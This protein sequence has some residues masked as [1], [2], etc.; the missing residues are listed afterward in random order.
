MKF[1]RFLSRALLA[2]AVLVALTTPSAAQPAAPRTP[3]PAPAQPEVTIA[4]IYVADEAQVTALANAGLDLLETRGPDYLVA[5]LTRAEREAVTAR[6][7]RVVVDQQQTA[8][9]QSYPQP[10]GPPG[11]ACYRSVPA[12]EAFLTQVAADHPNLVELID[13][14]DSWEKVTPGGEPGHDLWVV[15]ITNQAVPAPAGQSKPRFFLMANIHA[16]ELTTPEVAMFFIQTLV[17]GH[18]VDPDITWIVDHHE[19]W[20][21][22]TANPDG[23]NMAERGLLWRKNTDNDD[24]CNDNLAWGVDLNRNH[25]FM[26]ATTGASPY[27]CD[28][29]YRGPAAASEPEVQALEDLM[30]SLFP[31]QRGPGLNDPAPL[32]TTGIMIT[33]HSYGQYVLWPWG[34]SPLQAPNYAGLKAIGDKFAT[35][36]G[37]RSCQSG[38]PGCL[39]AT[40]GATDDWAYGELGI[41]AY[42][43]E[44]GTAFFE[45]CALLP[46]I[47]AE[48]RPAFLYAAKIARRPYENGQGPDVRAPAIT[49]AQVAAGAPAT[50][51][52]T[53][54]DYA[55]GGQNITLAEAYV[56][57]PP[58]L[59]GAPRR[60]DPADGSFNQPL[61]RVIGEIDTTDLA[62]GRHL[63]LVRGRDVGGNWGPYTGVW[64]DVVEPDFAVA[65]SPDLVEAC[66]AGQAVYEVAITSP[67]GGYDASVDLSVSDLPTGTVATFDPPSATPPATAALTVNLPELAAS[68]VYTFTV[69]GSGTEGRQRSASARLRLLPSASPTPALEEPAEAA[70][71]PPGAV[72]LR[73]S[74]GGAG[75]TYRLQVATDAGFTD[76]LVDETALAESHF[77]LAAGLPPGATYFWRVLA[78]NSCGQSQWA[79]PAS[80]SVGWL[81]VWL[82]LIHRP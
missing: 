11:F 12:I 63:V 73:W 72:S 65:V 52:A 25:S 45:S 6:G 80:F 30:R 17:D 76:L 82:P 66:P 8:S 77:S 34:M 62:I 4:R 1:P 60:L 42:T 39:Y 33:V 15:K 74:D 44:L 26:W 31:D 18:G 54:S 43:F 47:W 41:P 61:E 48:N 14:G 46:G 35:F 3:A 22:A 64:L 57:T 21:V 28:Q 32:N 67:T 27:P 23:R 59:G 50:L 24:G 2:L 81:R 5:L 69:T 16:R 51:R 10:A 71:L 75:V 58:W 53:V 9:L 55:N 68:G 56:D 49:P 36:N 79:G 20:V 78:E 40:S 13:Y 37:Y 19:T 7:Y 70:V 29:T 38:A